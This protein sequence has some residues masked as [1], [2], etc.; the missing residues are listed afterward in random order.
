MAV[1]QTGSV[2]LVILLPAW[3]LR[4]EATE[5]EWCKSSLCCPCPASHFR[6][7]KP[8]PLVSNSPTSSA[9]Q[10]KQPC[11]GT[12]LCLHRSSESQSHLSIRRK[13]RPQL[14][15]GSLTMLFHR[16]CY[17]TGLQARFVA[18]GLRIQVLWRYRGKDKYL[19]ARSGTCHMHLSFSLRSVTQAAA[20]ALMNWGRRHQGRFRSQASGLGPGTSSGFQRDA[21]V[22]LPE[23]NSSFGSADCHGA[24]CSLSTY[25]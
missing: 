6:S 3:L 16:D 19:A 18:C 10:P 17:G 25:L 13:S 21:S 11:S 20:E 4:E 8:C 2:G 7:S 5:I 9:L 22:A 15:H 12:R 24:L 1:L 14:T 23:N